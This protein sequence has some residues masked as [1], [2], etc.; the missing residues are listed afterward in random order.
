MFS[1]SFRSYISYK[2]LCFTVSYFF[3]CI[4]NCIKDTYFYS[5]TVNS[6]HLAQLQLFRRNIP[7]SFSLSTYFIYFLKSSFSFSFSVYYVY[8]VSTIRSLKS[9]NKSSPLLH[10]SLKAYCYS[11]SYSSFFYLFC[12]C[13][14]KYSLSV[15][16]LISLNYS[17]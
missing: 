11:I 8:Y 12:S 3:F 4:V 15:F 9:Y 13:L 10:F 16:S 6:P 5:S 14:I 17:I 2:N 1:L 7:G